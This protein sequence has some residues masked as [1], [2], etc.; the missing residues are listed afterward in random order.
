M[1]DGKVNKLETFC[2]F[3]LVL[4][5]RRSGNAGKDFP[6]YSVVNFENQRC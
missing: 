5:M 2:H 3:L 1:G 6:S 4:G